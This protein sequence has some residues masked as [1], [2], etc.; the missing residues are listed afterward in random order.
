MFRRVLL[1]PISSKNKSQ[2]RNADKQITN[3]GC[4]ANGCHA[5]VNKYKPAR[6]SEA[7]R[8]GKKIENK[9]FVTQRNRQNSTNP[10]LA[11][12]ST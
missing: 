9:Y 7:R 8:V 11:A 1:L 12:I 6:L 2:K 3:T 10:L 4:H 5:N